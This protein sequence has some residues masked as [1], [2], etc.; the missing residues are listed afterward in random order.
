MY[1]VIW[2]Y[3]EETTHQLMEYQRHIKSEAKEVYDRYNIIHMHMKSDATSS[4][5]EKKKKKK[6]TTAQDFVILNN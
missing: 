5:H 3:I 1:Q 6:V 4:L 2:E